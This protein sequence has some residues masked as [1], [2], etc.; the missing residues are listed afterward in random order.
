M[1]QLG[2]MTSQPQAHT[3]THLGQLRLKSISLLFSSS[4]PL[5]LS[6]SLI[7]RS[8]EKQQA[9]DTQ[10]TPFPLVPELQ[11]GVNRTSCSPTIIEQSTQP[12]LY[13]LSSH[14][15]KAFQSAA[16]AYQLIVYSHALRRLRPNFLAHIKPPRCNYRSNQVPGAILN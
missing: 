9:Q 3:R 6:I 4:H 10:F 7:Y 14:S 13:A 16:F 8:Q 12:T 1:R 11:E 5:P 2:E 15:H